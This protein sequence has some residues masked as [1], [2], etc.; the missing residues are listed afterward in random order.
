MVNQP[1]YSLTA[2]AYCIAASAVVV[3]GLVAPVSCHGPFTVEA[4]WS[5]PSKVTVIVPFPF[6]TMLIAG[7]GSGLSSIATL[8]LSIAHH[9]LL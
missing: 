7:D 2:R 6:R 1:N 5:F 3:S 8:M 4:V 9:Q